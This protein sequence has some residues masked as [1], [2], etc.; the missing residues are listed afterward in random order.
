MT[1]FIAAL[2]LA[3]GALGW[4]G[5]SEGPEA[6]SLK[7]PGVAQW[8]PDPVAAW[9]DTVRPGPRTHVITPTTATAL[10]AAFDTV[11]CGAEIR[12]QAGTVYSRPNGYLWDNMAGKCTGT[13]WIVITTDTAA[14][15]GTSLS[16]RVD[17]T[18]NFAVLTCTTAFCEAINAK[19]NGEFGVWLQLV[20]VTVA[21]NDNRDVIELGIGSQAGMDPE[22]FVFD[23]VYV[24]GP[25]YSISPRSDCRTLIKANAQ[26][27]AVLRSVVVWCQNNGS[28]DTQAFVMWNSLG[29]VMLYRNLFIAGDENVIFGGADP[30]NRAHIPSD[31]TIVGNHFFH[32]HQ[33]WIDSPTWSIKNCFELK[34]AIRVHIEAN[35][36]E[37][38]W[39]DS[40]TGACLNIKTTNQSGQGGS[41]DTIA[42]T[43]HVHIVRNLID[44]VNTAFKFNR[45]SPGP[46]TPMHHLLIEQTWI[47]RLGPNGD[48]YRGNPPGNTGDDG[49][50]MWFPA[51]PDSVT[52][53]S[54]RV[55]GVGNHSVLEINGS[56]GSGF[57][58]DNAL[59]LADTRFGLRQQPLSTRYPGGIIFTGNVAVGDQASQ[60]GGEP[61]WS[62]PASEPAG[63]GLTVGA[64]TAAIKA[65]VCGVVSGNFTGECGAAPPI[66]ADLFVAKTGPD[67]VPLSATITY[68]ITTSNSG[69]DTSFTTVV[70]DTLPAGVSFVS[71]SRSGS[72]SAGVVTWPTVNLAAGS[73]LVDTV[74]VTAPGVTST[75]NDV[76]VVTSTTADPDVG[77]RKSIKTTRV[78]DPV[79]PGTNPTFV[80][81]TA[82]G[83]WISRHTWVNRTFGGQTFV[84]VRSDSMPNCSWRVR[85]RAIPFVAGGEFLVRSKCMPPVPRLD[86]LQTDSI[87]TA[88]GL[89]GG[90]SFLRNIPIGGN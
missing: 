27:V 11:S 1:R 54:Y 55:E 34:S 78:A 16:N 7:A 5:T 8:D 26:E 36:F 68:V 37:G 58:L 87:A 50:P 82:P 9:P 85:S 76:G 21:H 10:Q 57:R 25:P 89:T 20:E 32:P 51:P 19:R 67:S 28:G 4:F 46:G 30:L 23:R 35:V 39:P 3:L 14:L 80:G 49:R 60:F 59:S 62:F 72:H 79:A 88:W 64:D 63:G 77:D 66:S 42:E 52:V 41:A 13:N 65:A 29:R 40:Q 83:V 17:S 73:A 47:K 45:I 2:T 70:R 33:Y 12:L 84:W 38:M 74:I 69:P 15:S 24:H 6:G 90:V 43:S 75:L 61:G 53:R 81:P 18:L 71:A 22:R 31:I 56:G 44:N 48:Y 86:S